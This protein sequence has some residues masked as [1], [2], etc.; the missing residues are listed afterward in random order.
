MYMYV[1]MNLKT[2]R[3]TKGITQTELE[4]LSGVDQTTISDLESGRKRRPSLETAV[5]IAR[6]LGVSPEELFPIPESPKTTASEA[7]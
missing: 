5:R 3:K 7:T 6:A 4:R 1:C 2:A